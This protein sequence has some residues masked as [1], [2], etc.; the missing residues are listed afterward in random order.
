LKNIQISYNLPNKF[1]DK[2]KIKSAKI[3]VNG[4]NLWTLTKMDGFDPERD[5]SQDN[6]WYDYPSVKTF[7]CGIEIDF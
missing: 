1:L 3:F 6:N 4:Q 5:M 2:I 7:T